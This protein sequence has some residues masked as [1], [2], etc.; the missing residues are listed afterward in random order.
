MS[1]LINLK[2]VVNLNANHDK[3]KWVGKNDHVITPDKQACVQFHGDHMK[4][5]EFCEAAD[6]ALKGTNKG[7]ELVHGHCNDGGIYTVQDIHWSS[8]RDGVELT[9]W[10]KA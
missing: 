9:L 8:Y 7:L 2:D 1:T 5:V 10:T 4:I 3:G 6:S